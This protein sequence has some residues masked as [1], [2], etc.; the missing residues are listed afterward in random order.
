M[1]LLIKA[2]MSRVGQIPTN[3]QKIILIRHADSCDRV[4]FAESC[5]K[6]GVAHDDLERPLSKKGKA[7]SQK[8]ASFLKARKSQ[9]PIS[10]V[11]CSPAKRTK[12][13][14][15]PFLKDFKG[16]YAEIQSIAPD[17][18][19]EGY[20][21]AIKNAKNSKIVALIGHQFDLGNFV[22]YTTGLK[23]NLDFKK[24]VI[25]EIARKMGA[26]AIKNGFVLTLLITPEYL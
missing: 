9:M 13:T 22:E 18:G 21:N 25:V 14:I 11:L 24:G 17:C 15:K 19:I 23:Q 5:A 7:Q 4:K 26:K 12:Q 3:L 1:K 2:K 16:K 8:I 10:L 6:N 20:L